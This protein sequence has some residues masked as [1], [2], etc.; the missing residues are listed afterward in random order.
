MHGKKSNA[1]SSAQRELAA[2]APAA[3]RGR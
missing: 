1:H 3:K 2:N